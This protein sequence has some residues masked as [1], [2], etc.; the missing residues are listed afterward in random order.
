VYEYE[1]ARN[2][3]V[4]GAPPLTMTASAP[5]K[6]HR[7]L[8]LDDIATAPPS[9]T[10]PG[11]INF[12]EQQASWAVAG[13]SLYELRS[14]LEQH[15]AADLPDPLRPRPGRGWLTFRCRMWC[16]FRCR[17]TTGMRRQMEFLNGPLPLTEQAAT[18]AL[19]SAAGL[20]CS[21][22]PSAFQSYLEREIPSLDPMAR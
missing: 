18:L 19:T 14:Q 21:T 2:L 22:S 15:V 17:L 11:T 20:G 3:R 4:S 1:H 12:G 16:S 10:E 9:C 13:S 7:R 8:F 5:N 6:L